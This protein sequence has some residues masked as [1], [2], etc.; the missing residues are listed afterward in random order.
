MSCS[1]ANLPAR[2]V[3]QRIALGHAVANGIGSG[4]E[5][6]C[7]IHGQVGANPR[8]NSLGLDTLQLHQLLLGTGKQAA[9]FHSARL[10]NFWRIGNRK[11]VISS[12]AHAVC[13]G[14]LQELAGVLDWDDTA[15]AAGRF[16]LDPAID[17]SATGAGDLLNS[18]RATKTVDIDEAGSRACCI[19]EKCY[20]RTNTLS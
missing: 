4:C 11:E 16:R 17:A 18:V 20:N 13:L 15:G 19:A 9:L 6:L 10:R 14:E 5:T 7:A 12:Y 8:P 3:A 1:Q 2:H